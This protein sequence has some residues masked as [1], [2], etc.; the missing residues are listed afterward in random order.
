MLLGGE[1]RKK[2]VSLQR[3][4][5][6]DNKIQDYFLSLVRYSIGASDLPPSK[7]KPVEWKGV[8]EMA[9]AQAMLGI[10]ATG[11]ERMDDSLRPTLTLTMRWAMNT[12]EIENRNKDLNGK[13]V[14]LVARLEADSLQACVLK[15]QGAAM[16]YP[17]P[18]RRQSG[19]IDVW[20]PGGHRRLMC[21]VRRRFPAVGAYYHHADYPVFPE[22][23][24]ELHFM[25]SW[26]CNPFYDRRLQRWFEAEAAGQFAH[27]V[28]LPGGVGGVPV[29]TT[30]FNVVYM[31]LHI[32]RHLF[33][34]GIGLRQCLDYYYVLKAFSDAPAGERAEAVVA[35]RRLGLYKFARAL[36]FV[37]G[38]VFAMPAE[39]MIVPP[40]A[41]CGRFV[42]GE[43]LKAGN[44]GCHSGIDRSNGKSLRFYAT[45]LRYKM[46]FL[47]RFPGETLWGLYFS[48]WAKAW[49]AFNGYTD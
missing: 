36:M 15:G 1:C 24:V 14:E 7:M 32:Y 31:L 13:C 4:S 17:N 34:E 19:D 49:R 30:R 3:L 10:C 5:Y 16:Y 28:S 29:P 39:W 47:A 46:H 41:G 45:K 8:Y 42:L 33:A 37:L 18:A 11:I 40:T 2:C 22:V 26:M 25:P 9:A 44:F 12:I 48:L 43:V 21:Y 20:V 23:P 6:M 35:I 38:H 27:V